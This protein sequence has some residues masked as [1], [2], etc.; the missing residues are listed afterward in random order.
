MI[1]D[2]KRLD[3]LQSTIEKLNDNQ[4]SAAAERRKSEKALSDF[5]RDTARDIEQTARLPART[6]MA[7]QLTR[8]YTSPQ[9]YED[10][11]LSDEDYTSAVATINQAEPRASYE[12]SMDYC[13]IFMHSRFQKFQLS[14]Q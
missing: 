5:C 9:L 8:A 13:L 7:P 11:I 4:K 14:W 6:F 3:E 10:C 2:V 1:A 12:N